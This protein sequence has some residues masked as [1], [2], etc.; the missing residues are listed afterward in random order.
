[1]S[2]EIISNINVDFYDKKYLM[3]NAK[4]YDDV[5]RWIYI[6]CYSKGEL[7]NL[8]ASKHTAY[9]RYRKADGHGVLNTCRINYKGQALVELTEQ[10]LS[11]SGVCYVD[12]I[13][14]EK[15]SAIID[16][17]TGDI[18]TIDNSPII[19]T[20]AFC[21]NVHEAAF[22]NSL[23]ES[24]YEFDALNDALQTANAEY[25]EVIQLAKSYA[26]GDADDIR[27]NENFDNSKY[28]YQLSKSH[29]IGNSGIRTGENTDNSKYYSE[30]S[31]SSAEDSEAAKILSEVAQVASEEARDASKDAQS[32]SEEAQ[33]KSEEAQAAAE[34]AQGLAEIAQGKSEEAQAASEE[35]R[36]ASVVAQGKAEEAQGKAEAAKSAAE[37][38]QAASEEARDASVVAQGKAEEA[39]QAA[40]N[41]AENAVSDTLSLINEYVATSQEYA[42]NAE[43]SQTLA[44]DNATLAKSYAVGGTGTRENE[45]ED[46]A[47]YYYE[48]T[49]DA[50]NI[51]FII[52]SVDEV[53]EYLDI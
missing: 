53:K 10:M 4:Q 38:A 25:K 11:V 2:L 14:V 42:S 28:Y 15:G 27:E 17:D 20:M 12:L 30:Q 51:L 44:L 22:D 21:I 36:D 47:K 49:R 18:V 29:S 35:A 3:I 24:S 6:T 5:S 34:T 16:I 40:L 1:M 7:F 37:E 33:G 48:L 52:S 46:N 50:A 26:I 8:S 9:I 32:K 31:H 39:Q 41:A 19:S 45:D 23:V 13:I 43:T